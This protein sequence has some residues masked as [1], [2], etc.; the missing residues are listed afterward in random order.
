MV[1]SKETADLK[2]QVAKDNANRSASVVHA[3][4]HIARAAAAKPEP[5]KDESPLVSVEFTSAALALLVKS[6][7]EAGYKDRDDNPVG[8]ELQDL[9]IGR[10]RLVTKLKK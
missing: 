8:V 10:V 6:L 4:E 2:T 3:E 9:A 5:K 1:T 7:N